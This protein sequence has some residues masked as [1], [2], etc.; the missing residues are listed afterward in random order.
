MFNYLFEYNN[1]F[2]I[3]CHR[4]C[5]HRSFG[6]IVLI[7]ILL[8]SISLGAEDPVDADSVRNKVLNTADYFFTAV[9]TVEIGLK[10]R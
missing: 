4:V 7:C 8:S 6:Y 5:N 9:F 3:F 1:R 10:V 2:R